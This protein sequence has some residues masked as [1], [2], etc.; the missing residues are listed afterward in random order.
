MDCFVAL[1]MTKLMNILTK[2]N[3]VDK[4]NCFVVLAGD[5]KEGKYANKS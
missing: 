4:I 2:N 5:R 3:L 1:A